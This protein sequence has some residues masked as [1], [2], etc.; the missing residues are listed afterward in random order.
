MKI[1]KPFWMGKFEVTN[2]QY[3]RFDSEHDSKFE[4]KGSW[5]FSE[6][7]LGWRLNHP[8]QPVVR[9]SWQE[10]AEFCR[11]LSDKIGQKVTL[12][13]ES[14]WEWACRAGT[15]SEM[16]YGDLDA[17]FSRFANMADVTIRQLAYD[18]DGRYTMDITPRDERFDDKKLVTANVGT[19][20]PNPWGL[21]DMHGNAWEWTRSAYKPYPYSD[22]DGRESRDLIGLGMKTIRGGSWRDRPKCCRSAFRLSYPAWQKVYNTGFRVVIEPA[23]PVRNSVTHKMTQKEEI[24]NGARKTPV[25]AQV[26]KAQVNSEQPESSDK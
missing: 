23:R 26:P 21:Y 1:A 24:S 2:E 18:T 15:D 19:Y 6:G 5:V 14:Q 10:A 20:R 25:V 8:K 4:H 22:T 13:M 3:A 7:H 17:D 12:P 9:V 11:W 16:Y